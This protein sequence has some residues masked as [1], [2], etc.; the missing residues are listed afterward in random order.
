M[1][2]FGKSKSRYRLAQRSWTIS[3]GL[4]LI[5]GLVTI[6]FESWIGLHAIL[7]LVVLAFLTGRLVYGFVGP[8]HFRL[9]NLIVDPDALINDARDEAAQWERNRNAAKLG[10]LSLFLSMGLTILIGL[11]AYCWH[12]LG[13]TTPSILVGLHA[14]GVLFVFFSLLLR[15]MATGYLRKIIAQ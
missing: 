15:Y 3:F 7:G 2:L 13:G 6:F 14:L 12:L 8:R 1:K 9:S 4:T 10:V 11:V 5:T